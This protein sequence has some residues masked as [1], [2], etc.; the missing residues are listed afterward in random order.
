MDSLPKLIKN[1]TT[2]QLKKKKRESW[3]TEFSEINKNVLS[4]K[5]KSSI[6]QYLKEFSVSRLKSK[7]ANH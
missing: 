7:L 3:M 1:Q 6:K 5:N 2:V 4:I